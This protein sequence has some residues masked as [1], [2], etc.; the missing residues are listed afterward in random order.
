VGRLEKPAAEATQL[1]HTA[2]V[3]PFSC[4]EPNWSALSLLRN[5]VML[6]LTVE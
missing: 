4:R 5:N 2:G 1:R 3:T 6:T